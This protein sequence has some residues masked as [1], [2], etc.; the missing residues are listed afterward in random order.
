M[1][2]DPERSA[3]GGRPEV[4][5]ARS[6]RRFDPDLTSN[7]CR[8]TSDRVGIPPRNGGNALGG[9]LHLV[10]E[11]VSYFALR[12]TDRRNFTVPVPP[13]AG[14]RR[15]CL[16][17]DRS[18]SVEIPGSANQGRGC[19]S[20]IR[21][22]YGSSDISLVHSGSVQAREVRVRTF[23]SEPVASANLVTWSPRGASAMTRMSCSP[24]VR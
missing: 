3:Y 4:V 11:Y 8:T 24:E 6:K 17:D 5:C 10:T 22:R 2:T 9:F 7:G 1:P 18:P 20:E 14:A 12:T 16:I 19:P 15:R 13:I 21:S 23:P